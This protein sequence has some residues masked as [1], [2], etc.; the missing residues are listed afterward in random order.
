MGRPDVLQNRRATETPRDN[1]LT[2]DL[3]LRLERLAADD[4]HL[5]A[6]PRAVNDNLAVPRVLGIVA[7]CVP[8]RPVPLA[9]S[10][11]LRLAGLTA[12]TAF[13]RPAAVQARVS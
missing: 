4:A 1:M 3:F 13:K 5:A 10:I 9:G 12:G 6:R 7:S 11:V 8:G 2:R